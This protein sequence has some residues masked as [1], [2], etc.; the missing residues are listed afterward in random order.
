MWYHL[1]LDDDNIVAHI[2]YIFAFSKKQTLLCSLILLFT[3][4]KSIKISLL[5]V[6]LTLIT[7]M[8]LEYAALFDKRVRLLCTD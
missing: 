3:F 6:S 8:L 5:S 1:P 7:Q 2:A 4:K